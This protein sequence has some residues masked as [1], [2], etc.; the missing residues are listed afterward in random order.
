MIQTKKI[1]PQ[2]VVILG[3]LI[4]I[5]LTATA[6]AEYQPGQSW[7]G[8]DSEYSSNRLLVRFNSSTSIAAMNN[9]LSSV[10]GKIARSYLAPG[11]K[12][13]ELDGSIA[14]ND[15]VSL[16]AGDPDIL[17]A[18]PDYIVHTA[19]TTPND[20]SFNLL[21]GLHQTS[22]AD[23]DAPE[24]WDLSTGSANVVVGVIDTGVDY[25]HVD[26]ASNMWVNPGEIP[27]NNI[28]D[29]LNGW[30]DDVYG[31]DTVNNDGDPYDDNFH[32][33]HCAGTIG[34]QGNNGIGVVGVN[35]NVSIMALK[36]LDSSGSGYTSNAITCIDYAASMG[37]H[38]TSNSWGGGLPSQAMK[39]SIENA[40][41]IF[42]AAAGNSGLDND[43][44]P[45]YPASYTSPQ[46]ISVLSTDSNDNLSYFSNYGSTS[47][48]VGAP[49]SNIY[50]C[51]PG[52]RYQYLSGTSM[53][54][55]HVAGL[56]ALL[57]AYEPALITNPAALKS[58]ILGGV[59]VLSSLAG[60]CVTEGRINAFTSLS[61]GSGS[62]VI[63]IKANTSD[64]PVT[65][66]PGD[67]LSV[68]INLNSGDL[69]GENA[70]WWVLAQL[71]SGGWFHYNLSLGW[72]PG[73]SFVHQGALFDVSS[74]EVLNLSNL[75]IGTY[76]FYFAVDMVMDGFLTMSDIYY[77]S[78]EV[79]IAPVASIVGLWNILYDWSCD[80]LPGSTWIE[81][82]NGGTFNNG[83]GYSGTWTQNG[84]QV[85]FV[86][87]NGTTYTGTFSGDTMTGT[88][89]SLSGFTGCWDAT[90]TSKAVNGGSTDNG[91]D[92]SGQ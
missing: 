14:I 56:A 44:Y 62:L 72:Q 10:N 65:I 9:T 38:L 78:V 92:A 18:E 12:L 89:D 21:W 36:F 32:G 30:V 66:A 58:R 55:P 70:D 24:A 31:I 67:P 29:D 63:D 52:N 27:G 54:T 2:I 87:T 86:Y 88:M 77:D 76:T 85:E 64:G 60:R 68:K 80:G 74:L 59:D 57:M 20:P 75:A 37:A 53:A 39:D 49:G 82:F 7:Q 35:W 1:R 4:S 50:S 33:T 79:N 45:H 25:N 8:Q 41:M 81:F 61:G 5:L 34:A 3:L 28:D 69:L 23:I 91:V 26:L 16:L 71:P 15:A 19:A 43:I 90:R 51:Q 6:W 48:D 13:I 47:V 46:I 17:Y 84:N 40:N 11:L 42:V 83:E 73:L 22:D